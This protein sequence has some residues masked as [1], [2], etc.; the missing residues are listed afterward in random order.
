MSPSAGPG[1][2]AL[3]GWWH[4]VGAA[5]VDGIIVAIPLSILGGVAIALIV[6][7]SADE[8]AGAG[9]VI[10]VLLYFIVL[11]LAGV[12]VAIVYGGLLMKRAGQQNGQTWG[13]QFLNIRVVRSDGQP[14]TFGS[15]VLREAVIKGLLFGVVGGF[16]FGIPT[17]LNFLWPL[18]D[19]ENRALH[20]MLASTRVV[21]A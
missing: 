17:L 21:N 19:D 13:K 16:F 20:D 18:W 6:G 1:G 12:F 9:A 2:M 5:I 15:A 3:A 4:R 10:G 8:E 14:F 11:P 7:D